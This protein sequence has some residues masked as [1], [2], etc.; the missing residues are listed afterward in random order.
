MTTNT[1]RRRKT[2]RK[3]L[4]PPV[5]PY[6][7]SQLW[8]L[9]FGSEMDALSLGLIEERTKQKLADR[10]RTSDIL[11][12]ARHQGYTEAATLANM[13]LIADHAVSGGWLLADTETGLARSVT[14]SRLFTEYGPE[15][16]RYFG[17]PGKTLTAES[18]SRGDDWR[19]VV[20]DGSKVVPLSG[21]FDKLISQSVEIKEGLFLA[22]MPKGPT[23]LI[24]TPIKSYQ[25]QRFLSP[26]GLAALRLGSP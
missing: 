7:E 8:K 6:D 13:Q 23:Q 4:Q 2:G 12:K 3:K 11:H 14:A 25:P 5:G 20:L 17:K 24:T 9:P 10:I 1:L 21:P 16:E 15:V 26:Y 22:H 18:F 19:R